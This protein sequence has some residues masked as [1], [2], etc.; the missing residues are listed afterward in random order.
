MPYWLART[1]EVPPTN[2]P[3]YF[4]LPALLNDSFTPPK[5]PLPFSRLNKFDLALG[6]ASD[7]SLLELRLLTDKVAS[8]LT[9][10]VAFASPLP[11]GR[12]TTYLISPSHC[13]KSP[14][15]RLSL[16]HMMSER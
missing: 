4:T 11:Y 13:L 9:Y 8:P 1:N 6:R 15:H 5:A 10:Q 7:E 2:Q 16:T 3:T 12:A 14:L